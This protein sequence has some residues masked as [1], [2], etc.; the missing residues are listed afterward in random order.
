[1]KIIYF[2]FTWHCKNK[3]LFKF[4]FICFSLS[5][6]FLRSYSKLNASSD[7][8]HFSFE[9]S[10]RWLK[11]SSF[12]CQISVSRHWYFFDG[13]CEGI[14]ELVHKIIAIIFCWRRFVDWSD[15]VVDSCILLSW[16]RSGGFDLFL[17]SVVY[18]FFS[19]WLRIGCADRGGTGVSDLVEA[20]AQW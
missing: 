10:E 19:F 2:T 6:L 15:L 5:L 13:I 16:K 9:K 17:W 4:L 3:G 11:K 12:C 1:M 14:E 18:L 20:V 7:F 8:F